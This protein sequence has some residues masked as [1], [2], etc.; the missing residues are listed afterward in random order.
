MNKKTLRQQQIKQILSAGP[1]TARILA[2]RLEVSQPTISNLLSEISEEV[3]KIG[4]T[5]GAK[6]AL[7]RKVHQVDQAI[8]LFSVDSEGKHKHLASLH[9]IMPDGIYVESESDE[10]ISSQA[11]DNLPYFLSDLRP[12]GYLGRMIPEQHPDAHYPTDIRAWSSNTTLHYLSN[13]GWDTIGNYIL[14]ERAFGKYLDETTWGN[15]SRTAI[16]EPDRPTKYA[17]I[18][19]DVLKNGHAGSSAGGEQ[20]KFLVVKNSGEKY[21]PVIVKFTPPLDNELACRR[22]DLLICEHLALQ[23]LSRYEY[24]VA[25]TEIIDGKERLFLESKRFDRTKSNGRRGVISLGALDQ[26]F[27]GIGDTD[28]WIEIVDKLIAQQVISKEL[29]TKVRTLQM[30]GWLIANTDMHPWNL[31]FYCHGEK[32]L[33]LAPVYDM[34]PM[35]YSPVGE[36]VISREFKA[37]YATPLEGSM[38]NQARDMA[39]DFWE[40]VAENS[41]VSD[42]FKVIAGENSKLLRERKS[43]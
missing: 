7:R 35:L 18:A 8:P 21:V 11:Y 32:V 15:F 28:K 3:L 16:L 17:R 37:R 9:P 43:L 31:S 14:G 30:F 12:S 2:E 13:F 38:W 23:T 19:D 20:P 40:C 29:R 10:L 5:R 33:D 27:V 34:L 39:I 42:G 22:A 24:K 6:Y 4:K 41:L 1:S 36:Q 26:E 25:E